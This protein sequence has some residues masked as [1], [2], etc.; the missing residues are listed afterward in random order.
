M[1]TLHLALG[2]ATLVAFLYTGYYMHSHFPAAYGA[3][4]T[5]RYLYR[6]NHIYLLFSGLL[7]LALGAARPETGAGWR[8]RV[9]VTGSAMVLL[10][11]PILLWSFFVEP[12]TGRAE[13]PRT[14]AGVVLASA[15]AVSQAGA[16]R[17]EGG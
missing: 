2:V 4:E 14:L 12:P 6:A 7:N 9:R 8:R 10:A 17:R 11:P 1:R 15:G 3:N 5:I 13:R 16:R